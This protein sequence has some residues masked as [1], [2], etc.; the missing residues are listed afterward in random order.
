MSLPSYRLVVQRSGANLA[1]HA[2]IAEGIAARMVGLLNR[3][4][5]EPGAALILPS[6]RSVHTVGMR[7]T[8]DVLFVDS[9]WEVVGQCP[10]LP[11]WRMTP[12]VW[13]AS[14]VI[15]LPAG[16]LASVGIKQ[17]DTLVLDPT[18]SKAS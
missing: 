8:I 3:D 11:P 13:A 5:L 14:T 7:F 10:N 15:E 16:T 1:T 4:H 9:R 6:C 2:T 12:V 18:A 17:G